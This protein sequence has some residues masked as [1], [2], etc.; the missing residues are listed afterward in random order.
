MTLL[1]FNLNIITTHVPFIAISR[2]AQDLHDSLKT[3]SNLYSLVTSKKFYNAGQIEGARPI[4]GMF[5]YFPD[6]LNLNK[7]LPRFAFS[8]F[9]NKY[10]DYNNGKTINHYTAQYIRPFQ[11]NRK[12]VVTIHDIM[13][14]NGTEGTSYLK[15]RFLIKNLDIYKNFENVLADTDHVRRQL[16]D[17]G[18]N[19]NIT[20]INLPASNAFHPIADKKKLRR[21]LNLPENAQL[22]LSVGG[23]ASRKNIKLLRAL[24]SHSSDLM[25]FVRVGPPIEGCYNFRQVDNCVLNKIYNACDVLIM[26]SFDEGYGYPIVEAMS[27]GLPISCSDIPPFRELVDGCATFFDPFSEAD[28]MMSIRES[29]NCKEEFSRK[30]LERSENYTLERFRQRMIEYY[31]KLINK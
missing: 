7:I 18:F 29:F 2:Y 27:C 30:L 20:T 31:E 15:K 13:E 8:E 26:P 21:E 10:L 14:V 16:I 9:K 22:I 6:G 28:A 3:N 1:D 5:P 23:I 12:D 25:K 17:Y 11:V 4:F 19:G 24:V